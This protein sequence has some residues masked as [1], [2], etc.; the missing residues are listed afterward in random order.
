[1]IMNFFVKSYSENNAFIMNR[2]LLKLKNHGPINWLD[3]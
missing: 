2:E 3:C 1:M